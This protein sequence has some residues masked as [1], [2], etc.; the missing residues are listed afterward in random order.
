MHTHAH[1]FVT[2]FTL[3]R[4]MTGKGARAHV[5]TTNIG[6][7]QQQEFSLHAHVYVLTTQT[8]NKSHQLPPMSLLVSTTHARSEKTIDRHAK[9][10]VTAI[11]A[12]YIYISNV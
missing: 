5:A 1:Q 3:L 7:L 9:P 2:Q 10:T 8:Q 4:I 12:E 11:A 6:H